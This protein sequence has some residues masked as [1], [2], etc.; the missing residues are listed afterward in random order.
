L[1]NKF[2]IYF[3]SGEA[4]ACHH[5][6]KVYQNVLKMT[7][8]AYAYHLRC[9]TLAQAL[10]PRNLTSLDWYMK[11]SSFVQQ[12]RADKVRKEE[13]ITDDQTEKFRVELASDLEELDKKAKEGAYQ[14]LEHIYT[15][16]PPRKEDAKLG[17][18]ESD[19]LSGTVKKAILHYHP[20][21]QSSFN[22]EKW[23]FLCS[24]ITKILNM[25]Y[26]QLYN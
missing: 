25:K 23:S 10:V 2:H 17:S 9:V 7:E 14:F 21:S 20:D 3:I 4:H 19:Q 15:K 12:Y 5:T 18:T 24:E 16:H 6:A 22:D 8:L 26:A 1:A 13:A 11:S